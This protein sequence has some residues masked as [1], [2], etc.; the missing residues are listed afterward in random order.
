MYS[1]RFDMSRGCICKPLLRK[2][3]LLRF[4]HSA[5]YLSTLSSS[6]NAY[7]SSLSQFQ[8]DGIRVIL[9]NPPQILDVLSWSSYSKLNIMCYSFPTDSDL[10]SIWSTP[11]CLCSWNPAIHK[12][13]FALFFNWVDHSRKARSEI[14]E[15]TKL[16]HFKNTARCSYQ[17]NG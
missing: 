6:L 11:I 16:S 10:K 1:R 3:H 17:L 8:S 4:S 13:T 5:R 7:G 15:Q 12:V 14:C 2:S 9:L